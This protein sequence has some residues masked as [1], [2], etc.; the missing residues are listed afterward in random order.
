MKLQFRVLNTD[1]K[2]REYETSED[3]V[4]VGRAEDNDLVLEERSVSRYHAAIN[5]EGEDVV[6][7]DAGS[8]NATEVDGAR[9][10]TTMPVE[11][12]AIISFG[13]VAV[14]ILFPERQVPAPS[15]DAEQTPEGGGTDVPDFLTDIPKSGEPETEKESGLDAGPP[16][17]PPE[18]EQSPVTTEN[19]QLEN[20][21]WPALVLVLG[22]ASAAVLILF[23]VR[24]G[25]AGNSPREEI[26]I[27]MRLGQK[28]VVR[29]PRGFIKATRIRPE[30]ALQVGR[31]LNLQMAVEV[32]ARTQGLASA[33]LENEQGDYVLLHINVLPRAEAEMQDF[34]GDGVRTR[35]QRIEKARKFM[36]RGEVR[37]RHDE[38]YEAMQAYETAIAVLEP[39]S[40]NP[41]SELRQA[42]RWRDRLEEKIDEKY[43][44]LTFEM[45]NFMR[46]GD[47][48]MALRR[49]GNI[50]ELIPDDQDIRRQNADL[51]Y[52]LL[53]RAI[54]KE[55][56]R[57]RL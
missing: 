16:M 51:L 23:F 21:L 45:T 55:S 2:G 31:A 39:L 34:F 46:D 36:K 53:E 28:R 19:G 48:R 17:P 18:E 11:D 25:G 3:T 1:L 37:R 54:E 5:Q 38:I 56:E 52:R 20:R 35:E 14:Q 30:R 13:D 33:R 6:V 7:E 15:V 41:P 50:K 22:L 57:R 24:S 4:R 8:R 10:D 42:E 43:D 32:E 26:G 27:A 29:V 40:S 47:K 49:L 44:R 9:V 12:G